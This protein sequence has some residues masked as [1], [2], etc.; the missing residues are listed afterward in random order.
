MLKCLLNAKSLGADLGNVL[1]LQEYNDL[2]RNRKN[3][4]TLITTLIFYFFKEQ[5]PI[6]NKFINLNLNS[7]DKLSF[8]KIF[9]YFAKGYL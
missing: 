5:N 9:S 8:K 6:I 7:L 3:F 4:M 1:V 2:R